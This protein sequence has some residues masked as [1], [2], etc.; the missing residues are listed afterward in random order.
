MMLHAA[1]QLVHFREVDEEELDG[2]ANGAA[3]AL[4]L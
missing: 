1:P 2:I 4:K 3:I